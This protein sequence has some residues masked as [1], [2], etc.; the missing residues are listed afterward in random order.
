MDSY[1]AAIRAAI[2]HAEVDFTVRS[3]ILAHQ[4]VAHGAVRPEVGGSEAMAASVGTIE[5][6]GSEVFDG[7]DYVALGHIHRPQWIGREAV[8]YAG[9]PLK[10]SLRE[11]DDEKSMQRD[12]KSVV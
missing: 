6:I 5:A 12:R 10:Y 8:R 1:D 2:D 3:V 4:F 7:F 11:A 9:S